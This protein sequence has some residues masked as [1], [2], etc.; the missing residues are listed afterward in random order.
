M[1]EQVDSKQWLPSMDDW[2]VV[3]RAASWGDLSVVDWVALLAVLMVA[4]WVV[5]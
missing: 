2:L 1:V 4:S 5:S 3:W